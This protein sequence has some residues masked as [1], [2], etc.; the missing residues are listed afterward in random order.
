[1]D[2]SN[3]QKKLIHDLSSNGPSAIYKEI[4][5]RFSENDCVIFLEKNN[6]V[7][8]FKYHYLPHEPKGVYD[9]LQYEQQGSPVKIYHYHVPIDRKEEFYS[10]ISAGLFPE[11]QQE[12]NSL[13]QEYIKVLFQESIRQFQ[14]LQEIQGLMEETISLISTL[15]ENKIIIVYEKD[16]QAGRLTD[17]LEKKH[18]EY[19]FSHKTIQSDGDFSSIYKTFLKFYGQEIIIIPEMKNF[20]S[21]KFHTRNESNRRRELRHLNWQTIFV[22]IGIIASSLVSV[23][24]T[25]TT[26]PNGDDLNAIISSIDDLTAEVDEITLFIEALRD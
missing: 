7:I 19:I 23:W 4:N 3:Y 14:F 18:P 24:T 26:H 20:I 10:K 21:R 5:K 13:D 16:I 9:I 22:V 6:N 11:I 17:N 25:K 8:N 1:M 2:L 15:A 12:L